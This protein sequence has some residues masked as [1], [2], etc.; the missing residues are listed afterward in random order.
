MGYPEP[1]P[2]VK[3]RSARDIRDQLAK[4][5]LPKASRRWDGS[6]ATYEQLKDDGRTD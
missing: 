1:T 2:A 5:N 6:R 3:G 4:K